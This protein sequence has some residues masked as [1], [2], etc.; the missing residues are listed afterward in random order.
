M[1]FSVSQFTNNLSPFSTVQDGALLVKG[2]ALSVKGAAPSV[3]GAI[4]SAKIWD[5]EQNPKIGQ[6]PP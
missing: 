1:D 3:K 2:A 6:N 5:S 4:L